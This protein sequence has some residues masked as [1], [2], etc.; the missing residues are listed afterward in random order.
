[1][2]TCANCGRE[3][4]E[5]E[6]YINIQKEIDTGEYDDDGFLI[7]EHKEIKVYPFEKYCLPCSVNKNTRWRR[8]GQY[9]VGFSITLSIFS[10]LIDLIFIILFS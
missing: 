4:D 7:W 6:H 2:K 1:M 9:M 5:K 10:L 3:Y 8:F